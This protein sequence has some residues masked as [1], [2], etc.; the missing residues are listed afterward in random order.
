MECQKHQEAVVC[1]EQGVNS[2]HVTEQTC[3]AMIERLKA[4][5]SALQNIPP[6]Q[7][8]KTGGV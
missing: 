4:K 3:P 7:A 8:E 2:K 6:L 5:L 1:V